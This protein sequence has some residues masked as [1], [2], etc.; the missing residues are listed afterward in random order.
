MKENDD[1]YAILEHHDVNKVLKLQQNTQVNLVA[2]LPS[3]D[4]DGTNMSDRPDKN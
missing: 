2:A 4:V 1:A 3:F